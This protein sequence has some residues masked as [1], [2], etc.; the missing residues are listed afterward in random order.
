[1]P[2]ATPT[3]PISAAAV[4]FIEQQMW[5]VATQQALDKD[6]VEM[7]AR[8]TATQQIMDATATQARHVENQQ[9]TQKAEYATQ[10]AFQVT[11]A[12]AKAQDTATAQAQAAATQQAQINTMATA[13]A[14]SIG[15][16]ATFEA[17]STE[18]ADK[19]TEEAP[20]IRAKQTAIYAESEKVQIELE[21]KKATM[22]V[23]AWG[24]WIFGTICLIVGV[25]VVWK[26]SQ[27]G[28]IADENGKVRLVM[29]NQRALQPGLM[30]GPVIDFSDKRQV[31]MPVLGV[32]PD[33]QQQI[34]H[35]RNIVDAIAE[36]PQGYPRQALGMTANLSAPGSPAI[37]IQ[38]VQ[39]GQVQGWLEDV[40]GQITSREEDE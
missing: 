9:A 23:S 7:G 8:M 35:E 21:Q 12:A 28:V 22:W 20:I 5:Q 16:T 40:Q 24:G 25:F 36:L 10:Q 1:M 17:K 2:T 38:V 29:I 11:V 6:R 3:P 31:T 4:G 14:H 15:L 19:K 13:E 26:R 32:S 18:I 27:I 33:M 37:N 39:P 30:P 34:V